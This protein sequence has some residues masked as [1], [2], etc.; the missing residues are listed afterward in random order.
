MMIERVLRLAALLIGLMA[1]VDPAITSDRVGMPE[2]ALVS[3]FSDARNH[4]EL[5]TRTERVLAKHF[6]V[7]RAPFARAAATVVVGDRLPSRTGQLALP[8]FAVMPVQTDAIVRIEAVRA[9]RTS[10]IESR[11]PIVV[12]LHTPARGRVLTVTLRQ[13]A[14]VADRVV[15]SLTTTGSSREV[16]LSYIPTAVG[17]TVLSIAADVDDTLHT[18]T[19]S[20]VVDIRDTRWNVLAFDAR[21]SWTSTFVRRAIERD[22]RFAVQSR[23]VTSSNISTD[24]GRPPRAFDDISALLPYEAIVIGAPELLSARDI[25]GLERYLRQR[26]GSVVLLFDHRAPGA[27]STL[28][29]NIE[30]SKSSSATSLPVISSRG[31]VHGD[32]VGLRVTEFMSP[33]RWPG[34]ARPIAHVRTGTDSGAL[35]AL[36]WQMPV[37]AGRIIVSGALDAWR[38]RDPS[39]S[40]FDR[41]WQSVLA[42]A[43]D[44][45]P[46][47]IE[48]RTV[49]RPTIPNEWIDLSVTLREAALSDAASLSRFTPTLAFGFVQASV[50][51]NINLRVSSSRVAV[52]LWPDGSIGRFRG[53]F[54][55]PSAVGHYY[56]AVAAGDIVD[57]VPFVVASAS[58]TASSAQ[59][60]LLQSMAI[61]GGGFAVD[62]SQLDSV[63]SAILRAVVPSTRAETWHPMRSAWWLVPFA[64]L[65]SAEWWLRRRRGLA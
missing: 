33:I 36:V 58:A 9:P 1:F 13:G 60:E 15:E 27:Y 34:G 47:A 62:V 61:A 44:V 40:G 8:L 59:R 57:S 37:G 45:S 16:M 7:L 14:L 19:A 4:D 26:G 10:S 21:P 2:I 17:T 23:V 18:A 11:V 31:T 24:V 50:S 38:F 54:R 55:A 25:Y 64:L 41:F 43:A 3:S 28:L 20:V 29:G 48:I 63:S 22:R 39:V 35:R 6:V 5:I 30:W 56:I 42:D 46:S 32:T 49:T 51:A 65:L 12:V 53:S 52:R